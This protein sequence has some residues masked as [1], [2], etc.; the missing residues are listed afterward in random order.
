MRRRGCRDLLVRR[1]GRSGL[2]GDSTLCRCE[3]RSKAASPFS[4]PRKGIIS[5]G[6]LEDPDAIAVSVLSRG[7]DRAQI[8]VLRRRYEA[9][10]SDAARDQLVAVYSRLVLFA[11]RRIS[12]GLPAIACPGQ[13]LLYGESGLAAAVESFDWSREERFD[14]YALRRIREAIIDRLRL[15]GGAPVSWRWHRERVAKHLQDR[16]GRPP[17][18]EE[19]RRKWDAFAA[20]REAEQLR[21]DSAYN[22]GGAG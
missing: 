7:L 17:S 11:G 10:R 8:A 19:T 9:D 22:P 6:V 4:S 21:A 13:V 5:S 2:V 20:E 3:R 12:L 18:D 1:K 14:L 16:L 15:L